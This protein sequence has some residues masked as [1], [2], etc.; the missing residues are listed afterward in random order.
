LIRRA[1]IGF[2][3]LRRPGAHTGSL[4]NAIRGRRTRIGRRAS[5]IAT[6]AVI[7]VI[8]LL[9]VKV[10]DAGQTPSADATSVE[11]Q[12]PA[13][14]G[15]VTGR[16]P[17]KVSIVPTSDVRSVTFYVDGSEACIVQAAPFDCDWEAG[18][19]VIEHQIRVVTTLKS[20]GRIVKTVRTKG[21]DYVDSVDVDVVQVTATVSDG[22]GRFVKGLPQSA[23]HVFEEGQSQRITHFVSEDVP[24]ELVVAVDISGSMEPSMAKVKAAAT[25]FLNAIPPQNPV[26]L[27]AFNDNV[28]EL[29]RA[30]TDLNRRTEALSDLQPWGA[31]ALYD[32][33][34]RGVELLGRKSG[35]KALIVFTDGEDQGSHATLEEAERRLAPNDVTL[36]MIGLGRGTSFEPLKKV[37]LRLVEPTGGRALFTEK[38]DELQ[39]AFAELVSELSNQYLLG[40]VP[41]AV[42]RPGQVRHIKVEV[43]GHHQVRARQSYV[44]APATPK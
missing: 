16:T 13:S 15:Y 28:F 40:Y 39:K 3:V 35:R 11:I 33:I 2:G 14:G 26:T 42:R 18:A 8:S 31:T 27:L 19:A 5:L 10:S 30:S 43:D 41:E 38:A 12:S 6:S 44:Y 36:Y 7:A 24:L 20:G 37:M 25:Q 23:F 9:L 22:R 1:L 29:V 4:G 21:L 17:L 32:S 34:I